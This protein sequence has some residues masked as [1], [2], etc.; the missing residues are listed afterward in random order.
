MR[1][2]ITLALFCAAC[3]AT[4]AVRANEPGWPPDAK[5]S[6][7]KPCWIEPWMCSNPPCAPQPKRIQADPDAPDQPAPKPEP[8]CCHDQSVHPL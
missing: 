8:K 1:K 4:G 5:P 7:C 3:T 2:L 6:P